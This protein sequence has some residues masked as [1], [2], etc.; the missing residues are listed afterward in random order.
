MS[1]SPVVSKIMIGILWTLT[2][3]MVAQFMLASIQKLLMFESDIRRFDNWGYSTAFLVLI[4]VMEFGGSALL[5]LPKTA[6]YGACVLIAVMIGAAY[7]HIASGVGTPV[8]A[9]INIALLLIIL[10][11]R[12]P[13]YIARRLSRHEAI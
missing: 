7:T 2:L 9:F 6:A 3:L 12:L 5:L 10:W 13:G 4:G 1:K 11:K 8:V